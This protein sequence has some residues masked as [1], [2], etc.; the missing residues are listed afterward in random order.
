MNLNSYIALLGSRVAERDAEG[1]LR[2]EKVA[3]GVELEDA[4]YVLTLDADSVLLPDHMARLIE[5][6]ERLGKCSLSRG[7]IK[8]DLEPTL[9]ETRE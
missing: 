5:V 1:P 2:L 3:D 6:M 9:D 8:L 4:E 7:E